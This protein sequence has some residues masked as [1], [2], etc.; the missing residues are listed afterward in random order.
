[1]DCTFSLG[2]GDQL[3]NIS[4]LEC[5]LTKLQQGRGGQSEREKGKH[6]LMSFKK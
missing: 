6:F 4:T 5:S 2:F 3:Y 1:M